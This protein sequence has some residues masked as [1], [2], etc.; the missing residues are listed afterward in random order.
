[1]PVSFFIL[2]YL[3]N[4]S[5]CFSQKHNFASRLPQSIVEATPGY[6]VMAC[7]TSSSSW[8]RK[9]GV[10]TSTVTL[11]HYVMAR[12]SLRIPVQGRDATTSNVTPTHYQTKKSSMGN[13]CYF[14]ECG[15]GVRRG[16][17][18]RPIFWL[19]QK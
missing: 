2:I 9:G 10:A 13:T 1:M 16:V 7:S 3:Y 14:T 11:T 18:P 17:T 5:K 12:S 6:Y 8:S 19:C 4:S 15:D